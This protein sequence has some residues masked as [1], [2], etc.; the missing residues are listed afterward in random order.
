M[1]YTNI[2]LLSQLV[3]GQVDPADSEVA[4]ELAP[5]LRQLKEFLCTYLAV[6]H[7]D[8]GALKQDALNNASQV[9]LLTVTGAK[10]AHNTIEL[11]NMAS[12]SVDSPQLVADAVVTD[13]I[14]D[15]FRR[16]D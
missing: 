13:K 9:S 14:A 4:S 7:D 2:T 1:P 10:I 16:L 11:V 8:T 12:D 6:S 15:L 5:A 3:T